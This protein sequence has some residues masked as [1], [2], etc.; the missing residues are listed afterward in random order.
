MDEAAELLGT[1]LPDAGSR[2]GKGALGAL[3]GAASNQD[4]GNPV[5]EALES[6]EKVKGR[7]GEA[8]V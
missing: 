2:V 7:V 8:C 3:K 5:K 6:V 4:I 1:T